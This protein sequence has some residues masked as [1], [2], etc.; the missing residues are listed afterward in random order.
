M[1]Q[2]PIQLDAEAVKKILKKR[3]KELDKEK[4]IIFDLLNL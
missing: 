2:H 3:I 4:G 1:K